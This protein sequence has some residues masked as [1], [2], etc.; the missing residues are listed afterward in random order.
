MLIVSCSFGHSLEFKVGDKLS[1]SDK[2]I[3]DVV[4]YNF[5]KKSYFFIGKIKKD[6]SII[7]GYIKKETSNTISIFYIRRIING[8]DNL[9]SQDKIYFESKSHTNDGIKYFRVNYRTGK[10]NMESYISKVK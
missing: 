8:I 3:I 7:H 1:L 2:M 10:I 6:N 4:A 9:Q 5:N